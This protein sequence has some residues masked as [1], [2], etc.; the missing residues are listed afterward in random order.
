MSSRIAVIKP[1]SLRRPRVTGESAMPHPDLFDVLPRLRMHRPLTRFLGAADDGVIEYGHVEAVELAGHSSCPTVAGTYGLTRQAL[2]SAGLQ[3]RC[4]PRN[5]FHARGS[6]HGGQ[7]R[8]ARAPDARRSRM[9]AL[10]QAYLTGQAGPEGGTAR[11]RD[12]AGAGSPRVDRTRRRS[13]RVRHARRSVTG[14]RSRGA[15]LR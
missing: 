3:R 1:S 9:P 10:L 5:P 11:R 2:P 6:R 8:G 14:A 7:R 4:A 13:L 15:G 12:V